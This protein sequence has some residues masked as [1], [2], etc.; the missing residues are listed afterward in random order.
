MA[1]EQITDINYVSKQSD[2]EQKNQHIHILP[3]LPYI[4]QYILTK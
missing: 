4:L 2:Y 3:L 1:P